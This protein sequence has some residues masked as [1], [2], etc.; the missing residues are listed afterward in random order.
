MVFFSQSVVSGCSFTVCI[1]GWLVY[2]HLERFGRI[3]VH[4][5]LYAL[6]CSLVDVVDLICSDLAGWLGSH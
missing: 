6:V 3:C 2:M 4:D 1:E 5:D